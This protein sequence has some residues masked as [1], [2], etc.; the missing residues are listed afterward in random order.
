MSEFN[1]EV[2]DLALF[3]YKNG[4]KEPG[5]DDLMSVWLS[6]ATYTDP[7]YAMTDGSLKAY[8]AKSLLTKEDTKPLPPEEA[9]KGV[10]AGAPYHVVNLF[11]LLPAGSSVEGLSEKPRGTALTP[12]PGD[13]VVVPQPRPK[14]NLATAYCVPYSAL[15]NCPSLEGPQTSDLRYMAIDEGVVVANIPKLELCGMSC[16]ILGLV[17]VR[18]S[19]QLSKFEHFGRIVK[20]P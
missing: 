17:N 9:P 8:W 12:G 19:A 20:S 4:D 10:R 6:Y 1:A 7:K 14:A 5:P 3:F 18:G 15:L 11:Q 13:L 2:D 16:I